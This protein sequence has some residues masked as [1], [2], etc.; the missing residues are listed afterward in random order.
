[1]SRRARESRWRAPRRDN[2]ISLALIAQPLVENATHRSTPLRNDGNII[3]SIFLGPVD[4]P[5]LLYTSAVDIT[6]RWS[7]GITK[8]DLSLPLPSVN[9]ILGELRS[10]SL[11]TISIVYC[12]IL[13]L[14]SS[15]WEK[16]EKY[17]KIFIFKYLSL[18]WNIWKYY[19]T[20]EF[21]AYLCQLLLV[22]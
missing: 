21:T 1:M 8:E 20:F 6:I 17:L 14:Q 19:Y 5:Y 22:I 7:N 12:A 2:A 11:T 3:F 4:I 10:L 18:E 13:Y 9:E 15:K 16:R